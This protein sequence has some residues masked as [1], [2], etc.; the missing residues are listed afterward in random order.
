MDIRGFFGGFGGGKK[1]AAKKESPNKK[2]KQEIIQS[3]VPAS[4]STYS[5][6]A[7]KT[8][9]SSDSAIDISSTKNV[10][11]AEENKPPSPKRQKAITPD[12]TDKV[13]P[14]VIDAP[15]STAAC[16]G[17]FVLPKGKPLCLQGSTFVITGLLP[18]LSREAAGNFIM[19]YGG[20]VRTAVSSKTTYLLCGPLL[21]DGRPVT[22]GKKHKKAIEKKIKIISEEELLKMVRDTY[23][24]FEATP[25]TSSSLSSFSSSLSSS[26]S[27]SASSTSSSN[28][29]SGRTAASEND[30]R[31]NEI[32]LRIQSEA[33]AA[34][35]QK[36]DPKD[37]AAR[38]STMLWA[39][40]HKPNRLEELLGNGGHIRS[41]K[42]WLDNWEG[43]HVK[44]N[45]PIRRPNSRINSCA[46]AAL[47]SGPPGIGKSSSAA[48]IA[49]SMGYE[50][51]ELNASDARSKKLLQSSLSDVT[52]NTVLSFGTTTKKKIKR[53]IVMDEV[54]GMS[55]GDR[56]GIQALI[57]A[58]KTSKTPI[59][60]ICNDAQKSSVRS[61]ANHC[62]A[63]SFARPQRGTIVKRLMDVAKKEGMNVEPNALDFLVQSTG[64]DIRQILNSMQMWNSGRNGSMTFGNVQARKSEIGKDEIQRISVFDAAR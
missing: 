48:L 39:D 54:D 3:N 60:C 26:S 29:V 25:S 40:K 19:T 10:E 41:L 23:D 7:T 5:I 37:I 46:K 35:D 6:D 57:A 21:E 33:Q 2:R 12:K 9:N 15:E 53:L 36:V 31:N 51:M 20:S 55:S 38:K 22:S 42:N 52:Q 49:R 4:T 45:I 63:L 24:P 1:P 62:L 34:R 16:T 11:I 56:G 30:V 58:I 17:P 61:L 32:T 13:I 14:I 47:V 43:W 8:G 27:S 64:G 50:V 28:S 59:I 44:K 18:N